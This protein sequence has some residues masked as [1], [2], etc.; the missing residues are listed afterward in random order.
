MIPVATRVVSVTLAI[1]AA[2]VIGRAQLAE[3][4]ATETFVHES[5]TVRDGLPVN[6]VN[7]LLQSRDGYIWVATFDGLV[8][9]DGVRFTVFNSATSP[10]LP[11]NRIVSLQE[12]RDG[13][14]W[15]RTEDNQ[16]AR[17]FRGRFTPFGLE[18]GVPAGVT[19]I[20]EDTSGTIWIGSEGGL[21]VIHDDR[22]VRVAPATIDAPVRAIT[23]RADG[24]I[25][26]GVAGRGLFQIAR[27]DAVPVAGQP[28]EITR[29]DI[30]ALE[31]DS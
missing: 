2:P 9:F 6:S 24:S 15:L 20:F 12:T 19:T 30:R 17:F 14:L 29:A 27:D 13:S 26:V 8:R 10:G 21:G 22:F 5:W 16:L 31:E 4:R 1:A 3:P 23:Q 25:V 7:A 28:A 18:R 11:S